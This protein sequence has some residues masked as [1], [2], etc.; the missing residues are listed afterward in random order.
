MFANVSDSDV[1]LIQSRSRSRSRFEGGADAC[2]GDS[3]EVVVGKG[4]RREV[5]GEEAS[6]D[7]RSQRDR[8]ISNAETIWV[9]CA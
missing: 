1:V 5:K 8:Q 9:G 7:Q 3:G 6:R 4:T 2:D